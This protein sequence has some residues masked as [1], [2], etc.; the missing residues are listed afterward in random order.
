M[1]RSPIAFTAAK[2]ASPPSSAT[3]VGWIQ[4]ESDAK[5]GSRDP[6][7]STELGELLLRDV[8]EAAGGTAHARRRDHTPPHEDALVGV[9]APLDRLPDE[10]DQR[11]DPR[12]LRLRRGALAGLPA[13]QDIDQELG[14]GGAGKRPARA[15]PKLTAE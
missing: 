7:C 3:S 8:V 14:K 13:P 12:V 5:S 10:A 9:V 15:A 4:I 1:A 6:A 2:T 11:E